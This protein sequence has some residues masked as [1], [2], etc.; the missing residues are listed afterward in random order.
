M[1]FRERRQSGGRYRQS[2]LCDKAAPIHVSI[3]LHGTSIGTK[4]MIIQVLIIM[5]AGLPLCR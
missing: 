4:I 2:A 3:I 5:G 1:G